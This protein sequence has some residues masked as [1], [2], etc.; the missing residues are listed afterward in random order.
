MT[1]Y[2]TLIL[3]PLMVGLFAM[4]E[5]SNERKIDRLNSQIDSLTITID[6][7]VHEIDTLSWKRSI[8]DFNITFKTSHL[9]S[10]IMYVEEKRENSVG[11]TGFRLLKNA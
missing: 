9:L 4:S 5:I 8:W 1:K 7:L 11:F 3:L 2:T 10:A 6:S